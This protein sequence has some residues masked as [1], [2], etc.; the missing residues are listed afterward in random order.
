MKDIRVPRIKDSGSCVFCTESAVPHNYSDDVGFCAQHAMEE[1]TLWGFNDFVIDA[2]AEREWEE[3]NTNRHVTE[4]GECGGLWCEDT[5]V[6]C[7]HDRYNQGWYEETCIQ[8]AVMFHF[9]DVQLSS[10]LRDQR[11]PRLWNFDY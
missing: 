2:Q 6:T 11:L 4:T 3:A 8:H 5:S 9:E 10:H 7:R 1:A